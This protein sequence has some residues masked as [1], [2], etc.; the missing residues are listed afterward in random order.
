MNQHNKAM[1][2]V[3]GVRRSRPEPRSGAELMHFKQKMINDFL[4]LNYEHFTSDATEDI[5]DNNVDAT[6]ADNI[7]VSMIDNA[8]TEQDDNSAEQN[9]VP[10][11][12]PVMSATDYDNNNQ[13]LSSLTTRRQT[14]GRYI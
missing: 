8:E 12:G 6:E 11:M 2:S 7:D 10:S 1:S 13:D 4:K 5:T 14:F 9:T 3:Y